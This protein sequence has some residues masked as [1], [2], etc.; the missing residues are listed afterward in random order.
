M[1]TESKNI[2]PSNDKLHPSDLGETKDFNDLSFDED[3]QSYELDVKGEDKDYDHPMPYE[4]VAAGA[5]DDDST[6]DEANPYVGDEYATD[7]EKVK[8]KLDELGMHID[9][10]GE[11][12]LVSAED[13]ILARTD[14]DLRDDLDEEGYPKNDSLNS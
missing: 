1:S 4:T 10:E 11:S 9:N 3:K 7:V 12:V 14:E 8:D 5:I 13:E 6:Y 2:H